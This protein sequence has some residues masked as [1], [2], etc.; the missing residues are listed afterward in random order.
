MAILHWTDT[1]CSEAM[2]TVKTDDDIFLNTYIL[3]NIL[4]VVLINKTISQS[5]L[6][7]NYADSSAI[8]YGHQIRKAKVIRSSNGPTSE[9]TRYIVTN[10]EYPCT[11]YPNYMSGFGY[12]IN[13]NARTKLLCTFFR[14]K[15]PFDISDVYV[16]G[17]L[18]EY[19]DIQRKHLGL[20]INYHSSDTCEEFFSQN[21]P[22]TYACASSLHYT[23]KQTNVFERFNTYWQRINENRFLYIRRSFNY[24]IKN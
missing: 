24:L 19:I 4:S 20:M 10:D 11:Y 3:A 13:R 22:D 12:I 9:L 5:K 15:K 16:T 7:C 18:P 2:M 23:T 1:Y 6:E 17:I 14:D 8:I 21:D